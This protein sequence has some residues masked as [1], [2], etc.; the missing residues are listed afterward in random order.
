MR[1]ISCLVLLV[2]IALASSRA[3]HYDINDAP[4]LFEKFMKAYSRHYKDEEDKQIHYE[5]FVESL[6]NVNKLNENPNSLIYDLN[7]FSDYTAEEKKKLN[8]SVPIRKFKFYVVSFCL[9]LSCRQNN[10]HIKSPFIVN[11][12]YKVCKPTNL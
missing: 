9:W 8:I 2:V 6:K 5:A 4:G 10:L 12:R 1:H 3:P 11:L 7:E